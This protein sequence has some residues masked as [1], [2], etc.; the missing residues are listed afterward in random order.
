MLA[1]VGETS[2]ESC[3]IPAMFLGQS[4]ASKPIGVSIDL[5][6]GAAFGAGAIAATAQHRGL[7][8]RLDVLPQEGHT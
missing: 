3:L 6:W 5:F 4:E 7:M 1:M 2:S 8:T